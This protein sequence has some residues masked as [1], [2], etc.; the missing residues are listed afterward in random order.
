MYERNNKQVIVKQ[1]EDTKQKTLLSYIY[2]NVKENDLII[3]DE[4]NTYKEIGCSY[5]HRNINHSN[6]EYVKKRIYKN[7]ELNINTNSIESFWNL[8]K[9]S[10]YGIYHWTSKKHL[11]KYINEIVFRFNNYIENRF[12]LNLINSNHRL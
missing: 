7:K 11:Q 5:Y 2:N 6:N 1:V 8:F 4:L 9:R 12:T 10:I 3:I